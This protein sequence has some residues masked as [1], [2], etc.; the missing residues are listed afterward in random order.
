MKSFLTSLTAAVA[1]LALSLAGGGAA[2]AQVNDEMARVVVPD[3]PDGVLV[4]GCYKADRK[5]Y[6]PYAFT[7][8]LKRRG[9]YAASGGGLKCEGKLDW[10]VEGRR[11]VEIDLARGRCNGNKAWAA[12]QVSCKALTPEQELLL[13][14]LGDR[15]K[16][17]G[18][19]CTYYPTVQ[20]EPDRTF[21]AIR[22]KA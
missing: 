13:A 5:L 15:Q 18:L 19:R 2:R 3:K 22:Q 1:V 7:F 8:C 10:Q 4:A 16:A 14:L 21:F 11:R 6:G 9:A 12:A 17:G 20:G